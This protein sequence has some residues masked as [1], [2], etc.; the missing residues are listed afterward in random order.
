[1]VQRRQRERSLFEVLLP[2]GHK[3][4]PDWWRSA[5]DRG[6][7]SAKNEQAAVDRGVRRVVLPRSGPKSPARAPMNTNAGSAAGNADASAAKAA[8]VCSNVDTVC[9]AVV[10]MASKACTAGSA[11]V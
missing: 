10:T 2:D 4:W 11:S 5:G 9:G 6:F 8:S 1:M 3:L 7:S